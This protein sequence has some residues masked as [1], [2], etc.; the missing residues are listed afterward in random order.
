MTRSATARLDLFTVEPPKIVSLEEDQRLSPDEMLTELRSVRQRLMG[1]Y[2]ALGRALSQLSASNAHCTNI[3]R[4]LDH[5]QHQLHNVLKKR[6]RGSS[7]KIKSRFLT[8][9]NLRAEFDREDAERQERER[10]AEERNRQKEAANAESAR[11]VA[12][13]AANRYF[14]GRI[15]SYKKDD[16]RALALALGVSDEGHNKDIRARI[17]EKFNSEPDLANNERF[18]G[19][20]RRRT[21]RRTDQ[22]NASDSDSDSES[23]GRRYDQRYATPQPLSPSYPSSSTSFPATFTNQ[24]APPHPDYRLYYPHQNQPLYYPYYPSTS[25]SGYGELQQ[26][27]QYRFYSPYNPP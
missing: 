5:V 21:R 20:F 15:S 19:L 2:Q 13:D 25:E 10:V 22:V 6:E 3:R 27:Y 7:K 12:H 8:S 14:F 9:R 11:R 24:P 26:Q 16:L 4:E 23:E 1:A 18:A 17:E